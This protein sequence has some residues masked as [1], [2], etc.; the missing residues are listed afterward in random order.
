MKDVP[1]QMM[2]ML[3]PVTHALGEE[4]LAHVAF[5]GGSTTAFLITDPITRRAVPLKTRMAKSTYRVNCI[6]MMASYPTFL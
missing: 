3:L 2:D 5:V 6:F 4:L 1:Q